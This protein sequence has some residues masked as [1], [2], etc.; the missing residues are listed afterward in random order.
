L[1]KIYEE[2]ISGSAKE[3]LEH[4]KSNKEKQKGEFVVIVEEK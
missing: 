4:F 3:L 2:I 1:T